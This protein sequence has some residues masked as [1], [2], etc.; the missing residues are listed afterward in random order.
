[1][2]KLL[3]DYEWHISTTVVMIYFAH[4]RLTVYSVQKCF[5][6]FICY[7]FKFLSEIYSCFLSF[8][9]AEIFQPVAL[10]CFEALR[11]FLSSQITISFFRS[12][13]ICRC[14]PEAHIIGIL[15]IVFICISTFLVEKYLRSWEEHF[16]FDNLYNSIV[17]LGGT[18]EKNKLT[19]L[20]IFQIFFGNLLFLLNFL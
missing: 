8:G 16:G 3:L 14:E 6:A 9:L 15:Y 10:L 7:I 17:F 1:M 5:W 2:T 13:V 12:A 18:W 20:E 11:Y 4:N 19:C